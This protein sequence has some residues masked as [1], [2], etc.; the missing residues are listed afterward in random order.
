MRYDDVCAWSSWREW[1]M[2]KEK[3]KKTS[4]KEIYNIIKVNGTFHCSF[5]LNNFI[6]YD[7]DYLFV[8]ERVSVSM[9][10]RSK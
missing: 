8:R 5:K 6:S 7:F 3:K 9:S 2:K 4:N 10:F 1:K